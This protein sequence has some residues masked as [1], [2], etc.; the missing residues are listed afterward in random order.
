MPYQMVELLLHYPD[1]AQRR[2]AANGLDTPNDFL[3]EAP[4]WSP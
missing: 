4:T 2:A 3:A 1:P